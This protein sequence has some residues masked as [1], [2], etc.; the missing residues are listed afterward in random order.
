MNITGGPQLEEK[1][2]LQMTPMIDC[3]FL[4]IIFFVANLKFPEIEGNLRAYLPKSAPGRAAGPQEKIDR[5][6]INLDPAGNRVQVAVNNK[7]L[8]RGIYG[9]TTRLLLLRRQL[10]A[11]EVIIDASPDVRYLYVVKALNACAAV[12]FSKVSFA[13]PREAPPT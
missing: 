8:P 3:V 12:G 1:V 4:L 2:E 9:L 7:I 13:Q 11:A 10:P 6:V 5:I